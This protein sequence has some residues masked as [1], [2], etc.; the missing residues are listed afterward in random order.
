[1]AL[2]PWR[3]LSSAVVARAKVFVVRRDKVALPGDAA[4]VVDYTYLDEQQGAMVVA[5]QDDTRAFLV[6]QYRYPIRATSLE[7]PAG[8]VA[9]GESPEQ[10]ARRELEEE[11]GYEASDL[12]LV[13]TFHPYVSVSNTKTFVFLAR[14]LRRRGTAR[15]ATEQM[16]LRTVPF[17]EI[18]ALIQAGSVRDASTIAAY[19]L[20]KG[21][22]GSSVESSPGF[23]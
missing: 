14:G 4:E 13:G 7:L 1:M 23:S 5:L 3:T 9:E 8:C 12:R 21:R 18:E 17:A 10:A 11:V 16:Q 20:V 2:K 6:E 19:Y 22:A 15:E